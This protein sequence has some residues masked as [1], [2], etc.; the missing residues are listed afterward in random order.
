MVLSK[1]L[2]VTPSCLMNEQELD[3]LERLQ[4]V[5]KAEEFRIRAQ[6]L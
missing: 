1:F 4:L 3:V 2:V 5:R 6:V